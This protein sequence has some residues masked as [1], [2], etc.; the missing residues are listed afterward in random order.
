MKYGFVLPFGDART[1]AN[2]AYDAENSG[3]EGF[4]VWEPVWGIDAGPRPKSMQR[5]LRWDGLLPYVPERELAPADV[6]EIKAYIE[7]Y[8]QESTP[9]DIVVEGVT[10]GDNHDKAASLVHPG[11]KPGLPGGSKPCG[12]SPARHRSWKRS[13]NAFYKALPAS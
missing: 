5:V 3:W 4:F 12:A 2:M 7:A 1:A 13:G 10:P 8:R 6:G 11:S 9:C